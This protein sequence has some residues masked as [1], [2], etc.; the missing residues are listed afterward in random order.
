[1]EVVGGG[2]GGGGRGVCVCGGRLY[3]YPA[4]RVTTR[5]TPALRWAAMRAILMF[6]NFEGQSHKTVS[7]YHNF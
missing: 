4:T 3:T 5:M 6:H 1:M 7:T 2:G